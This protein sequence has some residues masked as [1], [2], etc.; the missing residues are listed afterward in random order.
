MIEKNH[1]D[2][3]DA[4]EFINMQVGSIVHNTIKNWKR[5]LR[6]TIITKVNGETVTSVQ[7][8][9]KLIKK[10]K[11]KKLQ[12]ANIE[13]GLL[14]AFAINGA[15][16]PTLQANQLNVIAHHIINA[17]NM[18]NHRNAAI[19]KQDVTNSAYVEFWNDPKEWPVTIDIKQ[20]Q[21]SKP[22]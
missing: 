2:I 4:V 22:T 15:G 13:F 18:K 8:M 1:P 6:G 12:E 14:K 21:I 19:Y 11:R 3:E 17:I 7:Q 16:I 9:K 10:A 5:R 20:F